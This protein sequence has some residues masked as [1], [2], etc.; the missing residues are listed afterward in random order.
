MILYLR[1]II[2]IGKREHQNPI[3]TG[4]SVTYPP[5]I[6][7]FLFGGFLSKEKHEFRGCA[8]FDSPVRKNHLPKAGTVIVLFC[9]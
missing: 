1:N 8:G 9:G 2:T 6:R 7:S 4:V 5:L 3:R